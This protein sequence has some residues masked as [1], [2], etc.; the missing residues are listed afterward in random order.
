MAKKKAKVEDVETTDAVPLVDPFI[1]GE[2]DDLMDM[3]YIQDETTHD[4]LETHPPET[5]EEAELR[6]Q[7]EEIDD[8]AEKSAAE[9]D[10]AGESS[11]GEGEGEGVEA[12]SKQKTDKSEVEDAPD[13]EADAA[14]VD[15]EPK[16][17]KER[18]DEVNERRKK[19]EEERDRLKA[20]LEAAAEEE[21]VEPEPEPYDY[22]AKEAEAM[23]AMLEG[24]SEKY[25]AINAE[26]REAEKAELIYEAKKVAQQ[27][28]LQLQDTLTFEEAGAKI[29]KDFPEFSPSNEEAFNAEAHE[30]L[31]DLYVGYAQ[32]GKYTRV[33]ALQRAAKQ[34]ARNFGIKPA[35]ETANEDTD[36][37]AD[38]VVNI[39]PTDV[40]V[41]AEVANAQP[42]AMESRAEGES[43][44]PRRDFASMSDEEFEALPES[45]KR[46]ARGDIFNG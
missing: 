10:G 38:N 30:E 37:T 41:K 18:F 32:S 13:D 31:L 45:T 29:E 25:S 46:R 26:I 8:E 23:E 3:E 39:K 28:D 44:E 14:E 19:A 33:Q 1:G 16:I 4:K 27:G 42:P 17:P 7:Q 36:E 34:A 40:K 20:Q 24:D 22:K 35:S 15:D 11:E 2:D 5:K 12:E 43:E 21:E 9:E 6:A